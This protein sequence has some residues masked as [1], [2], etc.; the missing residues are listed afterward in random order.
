MSY[1]KVYLKAGKEESLKR[2]HPWIFSGAISHI[3]GE[4]D[5]GEVVEVYTSKKDF[6]AEGHFQIG[7]IAVRVLSF[8]QEEVNLDF[9]KQKL[10]IAYDMRKSIGVAA[11]PTNN[12]YRLV[13]G[14]G[15]N[16][17][18]LIIDVYA[19]TAVMQAHSAG[20]HMDRMEIAQAL[21]EVMGE[22]IKNIYYKSETTLPFKA[23]LFPENGFL[24]GGSSDNIAQEYGT[25][26]RKSTRLNSSHRL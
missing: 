24:K 22:S 8:K 26:D 21:S 18:G 16:L 12:T 14:E 10:Q 19:A 5:E 20:M 3:D 13:H 6:I 9:W 23:D 15:D 25:R 4:P 2:F 1:K 7:S 17:P 11:H